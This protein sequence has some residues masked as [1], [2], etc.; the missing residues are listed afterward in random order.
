MSDI[1]ATDLRDV[2]DAIQAAVAAKTRLEVRASGTK[3]H[4]GVAAAYDRVLDVS[5]MS[6]II[7]YQPKELVMTL[8]AGTPMDQVEKALADARQMLAFEPQA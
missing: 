6:G 5:A 4:L 1:K 3:Q 8:R 7:D 2:Q